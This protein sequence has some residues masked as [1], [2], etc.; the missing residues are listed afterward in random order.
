MIPIQSKM[1]RGALN[2][3]LREFAKL[4]DTSFQ[5]V[6]RFESGQNINFNN[7]KKMKVAF[8]EM[9]VTFVSQDENSPNGGPGIRINEK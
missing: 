4:A 3:G 6:N 5:T 1:A 7:V 9:G 2:I 8:E